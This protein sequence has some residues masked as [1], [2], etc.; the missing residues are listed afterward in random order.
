MESVAKV[1][2]RNSTVTKNINYSTVLYSIEDLINEGY[3]PF[4]AK[5]LETIGYNRFMEL[6]TKAR[7]GSDTPKRLFCWMLNHNELVK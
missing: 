6:A 1:L 7:A 5:K 4:Y 2:A 3:G